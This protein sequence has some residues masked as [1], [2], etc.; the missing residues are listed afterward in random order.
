[1]DYI[2][3]ASIFHSFLSFYF[4]SMKSQ[5]FLLSFQGNLL[6]AAKRAEAAVLAFRGALELRP[7]IRSYQGATFKGE[8][9]ALPLTYSCLM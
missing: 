6:L 5:G 8:H 1:M 7:D 3:R 2:Q 4:N 9:S